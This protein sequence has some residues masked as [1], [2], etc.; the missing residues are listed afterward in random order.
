VRTLKSVLLLLV[1]S[2]SPIALA[3]S[4][5]L[6]VDEGWN[7]ISSA[8]DKAAS[9]PTFQNRPLRFHMATD[10]FFIEL[11]NVVHEMRFE[12]ALALLE[13]ITDLDR[14]NGD[15][16][17][18]SKTKRYLDAEVT[19]RVDGKSSSWKAFMT[20]IKNRTLEILADVGTER[21]WSKVAEHSFFQGRW[22]DLAGK[23]TNETARRLLRNG[24][25]PEK[26]AALETLYKV[27]RRETL[28]E[29]VI[30]AYVTFP[31]PNLLKSI[32]IGANIGNLKDN[33]E[34][35]SHVFN[36]SRFD[37]EIGKRKLA[38][39]V[40][41]P[42]VRNMKEK[43][44]KSSTHFLPTTGLEQLKVE[45]ADPDKL[46]EILK[47]A[48]DFG[49]ECTHYAKTSRGVQ[50]LL[51]SLYASKAELESRGPV[52]WRF[53]K[54]LPAENLFNN[55]EFIQMVD[56]L[57]MNGMPVE[58]IVAPGEA[59][60]ESFDAARI[61]ESFTIPESEEGVKARVGELTSDLE[62]YRATRNQEA[63]EHIQA[64]IDYSDVR[65]A[66][67]IKKAIHIVEAAAKEVKP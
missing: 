18:S 52:F 54:D 12:E 61:F 37:E 47:V 65:E 21:A 20:G 1:L 34:H 22:R 46:F 19:T 53:V 23:T 60:K 4:Q 56:H 15:H 3:Q 28:P 13:K 14:R 16:A 30:L 24:Y 17:F 55:G 44:G 49:D 63:R 35:E 33:L 29:A 2:A 39:R 41:G 40:R 66:M 31:K 42:E 7:R 10:A 57:R 48:K 9:E 26:L 27:M 38:T 59:L 58:I 62:R 11:R 45:N 36:L 67:R 32:W 43:A 64:G 51:S 25:S 50:Y 5:R 8:V 6:S